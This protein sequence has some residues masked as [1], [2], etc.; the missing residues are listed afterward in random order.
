M[1]NRYAGLILV[2]LPSAFGC[3]RLMPQD[4]GR[5]SDA[6][7]ASEERIRAGEI[8][9]AKLEEDQSDQ[10]LKDAER[11]TVHALRMSLGK[12]GALAGV[13][14]VEP[15]GQAIAQLRASGLSLRIESLASTKEAVHGGHFLEL[16]V[17]PADGARGVDSKP[18]DSP[19][20]VGERPNSGAGSDHTQRF[21][22][23]KMQ[24]KAMSD[25]T[26]LANEGFQA[27]GVGTFF[28]IAG[29]ASVRKQMQMQF[30]QADLARAR[31]IL[32]RQ[33]HWETIAAA[34]MSV[35]ATYE[36]V[37]AN[38][39]ADPRALDAVA[40]A[41]ADAFPLDSQVSDADVI[42]Y[43]A[44]LADNATVQKAKWE[45]LMREQL[46]DAAYEARQK[47]VID[48]AFASMVGAPSRGNET[49][50][51]GDFLGL[52]TLRK[53]ASGDPARATGN[54][55]D[56][57]SNKGPLQASFR[58]VNALIKGDNKD[59]LKAALRLTSLIPGGKLMQDGLRVASKLLGATDADSQL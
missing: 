17:S 41:A 16:T 24:L 7:L 33:M 45:A 2:L 12:E 3:E 36:S 31:H 40:N 32:T 26:L 22:D 49:D 44:N 20:T 34:T 28:R 47:Q 9:G 35:L 54:A 10:K 59:A 29:M 55:M 14:P 18:V 4:A 51:T 13:P 8:D 37:L 1:K 19:V 42:D 56:M 43:V 15:A 50:S 6:R 30:S 25:A 23:L 5:A 53:L 58:G 27:D 48:Q 38:P 57:A 21:R 46:G 39:S 11:D 52:G